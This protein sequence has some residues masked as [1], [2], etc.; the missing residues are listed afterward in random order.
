[1]SFMP[2]TFWAVVGYFIL[3]SSTRAEG[4]VKILGQILG[5]WALVI[6]GFILLAGAYVS[7]TGLCTL[8]MLSQCWN[9]GGA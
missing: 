7:V 6:S 8:E 3:F 2:A 9:S 5:G 4:N 1:M